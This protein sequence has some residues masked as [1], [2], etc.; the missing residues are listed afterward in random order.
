MP[1]G[2]DAI[3]GDPMV[4]SSF[5]LD[6]SGKAGGYFTEVS[7]ITSESEVTE[8]KVQTK[9][10]Q[11]VVRKIPGLN[12]WGDITLKRGITE[13]MDFW[14]WR[15]E[16]EDGKVASARTN[17]TITMYDQEN[18]PVAKWNL[19]DAWPSKVTGPSLSTD[20]SAIGIEELTIVCEGFEREM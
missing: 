5:F 7:G 1:A 10:G 8:H 9:N 3:K 6:V 12:K 17:C 15:K 19:V 18:T 16:I 2:K 13:S 14:K 20:S 11:Q 4:G